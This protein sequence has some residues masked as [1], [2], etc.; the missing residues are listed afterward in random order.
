MRDVS[1]STQHYGYGYRVRV[2]VSSVVTLL[3]MV[4]FIKF[5]PTPSGEIDPDEVFDSRGEISIE[6]EEI[7]QTT[8]AERKAP[9]P[10]APIPPVIVPDDVFLEEEPL[11]LTD[12]ALAIDEPGEDTEAQEGEVA[13]GP[14]RSAT[15]APKL[16]RFVEPEYTREARRKRVRAEVV[17]E[18][19]VNEKGRV[20]ESRVL[21]RYLLGRN[22]EREPTQQLGYGLE[23]AALAAAE[24]L[25]F[26]PARQD[27]KPVSS[28]TTLSFSFGI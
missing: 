21:E 23:E 11:D 9:P 24:Q 25:G 10:P 20:E 12:S 18:V 7:V 16:F 3:V 1:K 2:L 8:H 28:Y 15:S 26:R 22:E 14:R 19:L 4:G 17:V 6:I 13:T 5:W 27:G